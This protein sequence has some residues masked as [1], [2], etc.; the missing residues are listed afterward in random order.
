MTYICIRKIGRAPDSSSNT[1]FQLEQER[2]HLYIRL[3]VVLSTM[4]AV[5][6]LSET[7]RFHGGYSLKIFADAIKIISS[8]II[9]QS[10]LVN[11]KVRTLF[12]KKYIS[13]KNH[14]DDENLTLV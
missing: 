1:K 7:S 14:F 8:A 10:L 11:P 13:L 12:V 5:E 6:F 3:F 2:F 4:W 9:A